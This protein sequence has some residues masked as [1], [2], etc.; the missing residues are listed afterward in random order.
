MC[1]KTGTKLH[2]GDSD[3]TLRTVSLPWGWSNTGT[4]F[5]KRWL[6]PY[7][8]QCSWTMPSITCSSF[9]LALKRLGVWTQW[10][11]K[12]TSNWTELNW[13]ILFY[14]VMLCSVIMSLDWTMR[15]AVLSILTPAVMEKGSFYRKSMLAP[16][17]K[18]Q[19]CCL[20]QK[21]PQLI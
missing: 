13:T 15:L 6:M 10:S 14:S 3:W 19:P 9:R 16:S 12:V 20:L 8:C 4:G 11:L 2:Q 17:A 5:L 7:A 18:L 1:R 21:Q